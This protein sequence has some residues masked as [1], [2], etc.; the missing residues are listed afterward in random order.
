MSGRSLRGRPRLPIVSSAQ[1]S[2]DLCG[3]AG[4]QDG[5]DGQE[6]EVLLRSYSDDNGTE[7]LKV[8][9]WLREFVKACDDNDVSEG[10]GLYLI[11]N[12]LAGDAEARFTR[13]LPGSDIGGGQRALGSFPEAVN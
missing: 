12:F 1:P 5:T 2:L 10:T 6:H 4:S 11:P 8:F 13:N 9:S 7:P 3:V